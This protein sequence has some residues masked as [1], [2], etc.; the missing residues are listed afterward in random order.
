MKRRDFLLNSTLVG[1]GLSL[2]FGSLLTSCSSGHSKN[3][4]GVNF[5]DFSFNLLKKWCDGMIDIQVNNPA[6]PTVHGLMECPACDVI[7]A[8]LQDAVYPMFYMAK[9]TGEEKYLQAGINAF[10]WAEANVSRPDGSWTNDLNPKSWNGTTVFGAIALAETLKHHSDLLDDKTIV[11]WKNRLREA[12]DFILKKFPKIDATNVNYGGTNIYALHLIGELLDEPKYTNKSKVLANDIKSY[13]TSPNRLLFGEIK[14]S[15]HKL[16]VKGLPGVDLGYNVEET[17]NSLVLYAHETKDEELIKILHKSLDSHLEFM[18]PDGGWDNSWG[19]RMFKWTYWGSRTCDGCQPAFS[20]MASENPAFGTA[21]IK[22]TELLDRCTSNGLLHGGMHYVS[23]GI[24]PC[25]HHTFT[26]AK[27]LAFMLDNWKELPD[28]DV[29]TPLPRA[30][31][32][33]VQYFEELDT[34]LVSRGQWRSTITAYDAEYYHKKDLRQATGASLSTLYHNK[35]GL[36]CAASLAVYKKMEPLNQQSAPGKDIALTPRIETFSGDQW[37]T[38]LF[39]LEASFNTKNDDYLITV[40]GA[41]QL[42]NESRQKVVN[43]AG[44]FNVDYQFTSDNLIIKASTNQDINEKTAF[45]LPIISPNNEEVI[46]VNANKIKV[47]KPNGTLKISANV[48]IKIRKTEKNRTF[49]M[50]PGVEAIPLDLFF[51]KN[52]KSIR[53]K[54]EVV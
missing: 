6:D 13:F 53:I 25:L 5:K 44:N 31:A 49:N 54:L 42:K 33:G 40:Q 50:V 37:Y 11:R 14:P 43:T 24:K 41:M 36:I 17:L 12:T 9:E 45:V 1:V 46:H 21:V 4:E 48:P 22:N 10:E 52:E 30:T 35:V 15:A 3:K 29:A 38:N 20:V 8:R 28:L 51:D 26:H 23:H 16:S 47:K 18:M 32:Q 19:T 39:D 2:P 7:H 34:V 27:S